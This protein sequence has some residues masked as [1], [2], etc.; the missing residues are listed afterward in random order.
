MVRSS[1]LAKPRGPLR[2]S[3]VSSSS[4]TFDPVPLQ[5]RT[6]PT[7]MQRRADIDPVEATH[8]RA[9]PGTTRRRVEADDVVQ[10]DPSD[11]SLIST[12][13]SSESGSDRDPDETPVQNRMPSPSDVSNEESYPYDSFP[14][15]REQ[16]FIASTEYEVSTNDSAHSYDLYEVTHEEFA[17]MNRDAEEFNHGSSTDYNSST[18][19][20]YTTQSSLQPSTIDSSHSYNL[21]Q[22]DDFEVSKLVE[23]AAADVIHVRLAHLR[24]ANERKDARDDYRDPEP[25]YVQ[26]GSGSP[27]ALW[28]SNARNDPGDS[29]F[30]HDAGIPKN[31]GSYPDVTVGA[32]YVSAV[33]QSG[34]MTPGPASPTHA[35]LE[36][37]ALMS[38]TRQ[39]K[40]PIGIH[41][42][43]AS[44]QHAQ[45]SSP[46]GQ[47]R[48]FDPWPFECDDETIP[49]LSP[50]NTIRA[51]KRFLGANQCS[52]NFE[53]TI[54][55]V[56]RLPR[57]PQWP[58]TTVLNLELLIKIILPGHEVVDSVRH[59]RLLEIELA[60]AVNPP[61]ELS[62]S[63]SSGRASSVTGSA[64]SHGGGSGGSS[65][66]KKS[67][68]T[69]IEQWW[70]RFE[71]KEASDFVLAP[72]I[73]D[74][75]KRSAVENLSFFHQSAL[76]APP[77]GSPGAGS[78]ATATP[79]KATRLRS[80]LAKPNAPVAA[81]TQLTADL[82]ASRIKF[83]TTSTQANVQEILLYV[84]FFFHL[85]ALH[86][87][88][89]L[90][91]QDYQALLRDNGDGES[92]GHPQEGDAAT[93]YNKIGP[94][95]LPRM[96]PRHYDGLWDSFRVRYSD[97][98]MEKKEFVEMIKQVRE[99]GSR[100]L[101]FA[102][103]L[104]LGCLLYLQADMPPN[105]MWGASKGG[106]KTGASDRGFR[107]L[108]ELGLPAL[109]KDS[110]ANRGEL[111]SARGAV[112]PTA[113]VVSRLT[114][115]IAPSE[116][117]PFAGSLE[118]W[119]MASYSRRL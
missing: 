56:S 87:D 93:V 27:N 57:R 6:S 33:E 97:F 11:R 54:N 96:M 50:D 34:L 60:D 35:T 72:G 109:C 8:K 25:S 55:L 41:S 76:I 3:T 32:V 83:I 22:V 115:Q 117:Q 84:F 70:R 85:T 31:P 49:L 7:K 80:R 79:S 91:D 4:S 95:P 92:S 13:L 62:K 65:K 9:A 66:G 118:E 77:S 61:L 21:S 51:I 26:A 108:E 69:K 38:E 37:K 53:E 63:D 19:P 103:R 39:E 71:R 119:M 30:L 29:A 111:T 12:H 73:A 48:S 107:R 101:Y 75:L 28:D 89:K 106:D 113:S 90:L 18:D 14:S 64:G 86:T 52:V 5:A 42:P 82:L 102:A 94:K 114:M 81:S 116:S 1:R 59:G 45:L 104:G 43:P 16:S 100:Y 40:L 17:E 68:A 88:R 20:G 36:T 58:R 98:P 105:Q 110:G 2:K 47:D 15:S 44:P 74:M 23:D 24:H 46:L 78:T 99:K 10:H 112:S 67:G